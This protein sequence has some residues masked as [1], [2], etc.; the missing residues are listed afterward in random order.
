MTEKPILFSGPMVRAI[1]EG[2]KTQTRRVVD[3]NRLRIVPRWTI[4]AD[5]GL[6][7]GGV[8][9]QGKK[10]KCT[11]N[12]CGAVSGKD[13][14]GC[15]LGVKPEEFD[16]VCPYAE[17]QTHLKEKQWQ[18]SVD[19]S[20]LWVRETWAAI[21]WDWPQGW[22]DVQYKADKAISMQRAV[23]DNKWLRLFSCSNSCS[24]ADG[25]KWRPSIHMPRWASRIQLEVTGVRVERVQDIS[26]QDAVSEG[27][28]GKDYH[29]IY[30]NPI[31][32]FG[33]LW[34]SINESR[35][36]GWAVNPWVWVIEFRRVLS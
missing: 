25:D 28:G 15:W 30:G 36:F 18:I 21:A 14:K 6:G 32:E 26:E 23:P 16:F 3:F 4:R 33:Q 24:D 20:Q 35:G 10:A 1:L 11:F 12:Q 19:N 29:W 5:W 8:L 13:T 7:S 17:G 22:M 31:D 27:I 2:Y 34:D 9:N